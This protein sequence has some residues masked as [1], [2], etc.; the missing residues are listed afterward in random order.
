[1]NLSICVH[2]ASNKNKNDPFNVIHSSF[3]QLKEQIEI[4]F[5]TNEAGTRIYHHFRLRYKINYA[6]FLPVPP[7]FDCDISRVYFSAE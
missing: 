2:L 5:Q 1:M 3:L 6:K 7:Y 4:L